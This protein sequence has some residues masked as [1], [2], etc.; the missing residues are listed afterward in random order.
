MKDEGISDID[1]VGIIKIAAT[2]P[3]GMVAMLV[4]L[5]SVIGYLMLRGAPHHYRFMAF[6]MLF[7]GAGT[8]SWAVIQNKNELFNQA[9]TNSD[10]AKAEFVQKDNAVAATA[11]T[12]SARVLTVGT[13]V[14][15][16]KAKQVNNRRH[17]FRLTSRH[18][19]YG[20][21]FVWR[22]PVKTGWKVDTKSIS[23]KQSRRS[24]GVVNLRVVARANMIYVPVRI[25]NARA[26]YALLTHK[27]GSKTVRRPY[28]LLALLR[29]SEYK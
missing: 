9:S 5:V 12:A 15:A 18:C 14:G 26:C 1:W 21:P 28:R 23:L 29:F 10:T 19:A 24:K 11:A 8:L 27:L 13:P 2:S 4:I 25:S 17:L 3:M 20:K 7:G 16:G 6:V 22:I